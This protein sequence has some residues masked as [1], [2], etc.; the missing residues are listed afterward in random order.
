[1]YRVPKA[2]HHPKHLMQIILLNIPIC[3]YVKQH[4]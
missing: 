3:E 1:M 4:I 2:K